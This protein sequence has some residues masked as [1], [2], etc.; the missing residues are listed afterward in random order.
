MTLIDTPIP[1]IFFVAPRD[2][3][4]RSAIVFD[5]RTTQLPRDVKPYEWWLNEVV[6]T[7]THMA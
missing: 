2:E 1:H 4:G 7:L 6:V 5:T 3:P